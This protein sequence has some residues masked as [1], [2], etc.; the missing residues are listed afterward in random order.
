MIKLLICNHKINENFKRGNLTYNFQVRSDI[1]KKYDLHENLF[2]LNGNVILADFNLVRNFTFKLNQKRT[3]DNQIRA[4]QVNA[5]GLIDEIY[6]FVLRYY[7]ENYNPNVFLKALNYL[8]DKI[9]EQELQKTIKVFLEEFQPIEVMKGIISVENY[10][11]GKTGSRSNLE[12]TLEE[13]MLVHFSNYNP[14]NKKLRE[15]FDDKELAERT[16]YDKVINELEKYFQTQIGFGEENQFIFDFLR[17]PFFE[18]PASLEDQLKFI[19]N[20]WKIVLTPDFLKK[21]LSSEDLLK[22]EEKLFQ[23]GFGPGETQ[24]PIFDEKYLFGFG[25]KD[26]G[27]GINYKVYLEPERFTPDTDWMPR[28]VLMAKNIFVWLNQLSKKYGWHIHRLENIPDEEL[29]Q[30]ADWGFTALWLIGVWERSNASK[31]IKQISGN[32]EAMPSAY[33][34]YDYQ[35]AN[36]LGGEEAFQNLNH[37]CRL[38]GIHLASDMV[39]NHMG[40]FSRWILE[41]QDFFIQSHSSPFPNYSFTGVDLSDDPA[42]QLRI[43]DGY[44]SRKDAAVVFQLID[45]RSGEVRYIYHGND[46]TSMP[47]NDTAQLNLLKSEV[48]EALIQMIMHVARKFTIIRFDAAMTLTQ[49][50]YQRLWFPPPGSGGD[51][52]SRAGNTISGEEFYKLY[53]KEFWREVVDRIN[54]E[55]P[56][57][58]LL[59]EAFWLLE[60]YFVRTLGMHRV[61]NSAFMNMLK[62]EENAKYRDLITNTL[63]FNPEILKRYVNFMS[64]PDEETAVKQFGDG[65]KYF[66]IAV[67]MVTLPGL[68]MF[69]HG[70][71]EGYYEKYGMEYNKAYYDESP[72][73]YLISRHQEEIFPLMRKRYLFSQVSDFEFYDFKTPNGNVA[74]NVFAYTNFFGGE[75]AIVVYNNSYETYSGSINYSTGKNY[76]ESEGEKQILSKN[77]GEALSFKNSEKHFYVYKDLIT[78]HEFIR[79]GKDFYEYGLSL[80]LRGYGYFVFIDFLEMYDRN[81][82]LDAV[83]KELNGAGVISIQKELIKKGLNNVK[84]EFVKVLSSF[85]SIFDAAMKSKKDFEI[86]PNK[87]LELKEHFQKIG[88]MINRAAGTKLNGELIAKNIFAEI[89]PYT[90]SLIVMKKLKTSK[91]TIKWFKKA[92]KEFLLLDSFWFSHFMHSHSI[93]KNFMGSVDENKELL[94]DFF[95][96][97]DIVNLWLSEIKLNPELKQDSLQLMKILPLIENMLEKLKDEPVES[98]INT[99]NEFAE[100]IVNPEIQNF[101]HVN[102]FEGEIFFSMEQFELLLRTFLNQYLHRSIYNSIQDKKSKRIDQERLLY[103][104]IKKL[105]D[106]YSRIIDLAKISDYRFNVFLEKLRI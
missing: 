90:E 94:I 15:L 88:D 89:R 8:Y 47:W 3:A 53:P 24:V 21:I 72:N 70:Q 39:P 9:G 60:G 36:E 28:V 106:H 58:L 26:F 96:N 16:P 31:K 87:I 62:K 83:A 93:E 50:H 38:R 68:P 78:K 45:N 77:L 10:I 2:Q 76:G 6:H 13:L 25:D 92:Q 65:D 104:A 17:K 11:E 54:S 75:R 51:I 57:T 34:I 14:A 79:S 59:A 67:M 91:K 99:W 103:K 23:I 100:F 64:N 97:S 95:R 46:G 20:R 49:K 105:Y 19:K 66:G 4:G 69:G 41:H 86:D 102:E 73:H 63:E 27:D 85:S 56:N 30:L 71:L 18:H 74:E 12:I 42:V 52:P 44:W 29:D 33:S 48:R 98:E 22:E 43:E 40:I 32:P 80:T 101:I 82:E 84:H 81:G 5:L 1:R 35:I 37:R 55:M 61:Y 7:E